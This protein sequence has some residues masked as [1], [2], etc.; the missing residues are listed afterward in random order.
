MNHYKSC[1]E[2]CEE[3]PD[4]GSHEC[5]ECRFRESEADE[6]G[7]VDQYVRVVSLFDANGRIEVVTEDVPGN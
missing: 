3:C 7:E 6:A 5:D 2:V 4:I 1:P